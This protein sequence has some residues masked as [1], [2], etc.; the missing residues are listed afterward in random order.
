MVRR[1]ELSREDAS[2]HPDRNILTQSLG[3]SHNMQIKPGKLSGVLKSGQQ[4]LLCSDG[5]TDEVPDQQISQIM[6]VGKTPQD[7]V[8]ALLSA[9]LAAGGRDNITIV[10]IGSCGDE[11]ANPDMDTTQELD[12]AATRLNVG[13]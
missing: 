9:A 5:L 10:I 1:G 4:L 2:R 13:P 7:Q 12:P 11:G 8:D 3:V 6:R